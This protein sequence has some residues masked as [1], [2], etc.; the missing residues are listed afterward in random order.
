MTELDGISAD[1][2][3]ATPLTSRWRNASPFER[4]SASAQK[5]VLALAVAEV[6]L[7]RIV[8][9]SHATSNCVQH[10]LNLGFYDGVTMTTGYVSFCSVVAMVIVVL[11]TLLVR[12]GLC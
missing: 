9:V 10:L 4:S 6:Y 2:H 8:V 3:L 11:E 7:C 5:A 1:W 12:R